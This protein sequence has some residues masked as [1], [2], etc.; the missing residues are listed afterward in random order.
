MKMCKI[1]LIFVLIN[2]I[3][4]YQAPVKNKYFSLP[5]TRKNATN[6][7]KAKR[8]G[9][10]L[11]DAIFR[12][13]AGISNAFGY[14]GDEYSDYNDEVDI[15]ACEC[16]CGYSNEEIRIVG[17]KPTGVNQFP[18]MARI[19]YDGKFHCGGS[20]LTKDYV[21]T[22][23]HCV[24]KLRKS[25]IRIIFGDH[26]QHITSESNAI[27]R[28]VIAIIK[29]RNFDPDSYNNDIALLKLRK[30]MMFSKIIK[31]VCLPRYNYNPAGRIGTVVGWGRTSEGGDLPSIVNQ[32]K[33][34]IMSISECRNQKYKS[35]RI[36]A[37]MLCAG[38]PSMD[39]C[40]VSWGVGC[41]RDGYP[42]VYTRV[43]KFVPWIKSNL[44]DSCLCS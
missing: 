41:G 39:S 31:P 22:A 21:L 34:P 32:V 8:S 6:I 28:A 15:K 13:S 9:K 12:I 5:Q 1:L 2:V 40:Q 25:K 16:D 33:V 24:K 30:P 42:G 7:L 37:S 4:A 20:L 3:I 36:T 23:A 27:Q 43:S 19:V 26:D 18:W 29:H 11:F 44:R 35:S 17:G 14:E 38:R 10:F